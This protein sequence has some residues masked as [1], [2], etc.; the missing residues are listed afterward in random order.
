MSNMCADAAQLW[1]RDVTV[2][3]TKLKI[4]TLSYKPLFRQTYS[5]FSWEII[6]RLVLDNILNNVCYFSGVGI[7]YGG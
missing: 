2:T 7:L 3:S 6:S 4:V 1:R 5:E